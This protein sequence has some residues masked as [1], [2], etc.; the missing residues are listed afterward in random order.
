VSEGIPQESLLTMETTEKLDAQTF[1]DLTLEILNRHR[2]DPKNMISQ[3]YDGASV[4]SGEFGGVQALIQ[5]AVEKNIPYI[6][7]FN[8]RLH[9]VVIKALDGVTIISS[10]FD[11]AVMIYNF[12]KKHKVQQLC[13]GTSL[14]RLIDTRWASVQNV[15]A[16]SNS[17]SSSYEICSI[18][19]SPATTPKS[20]AKKIRT[21]NFSPLRVFIF[22]LQ[23]VRAGFGAI[24]SRINFF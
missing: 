22:F 21:K 24:K 14:S 3:C 19:F 7:C 15:F 9:L 1:T 16:R 4:M 20:G 8:H 6:H 5:K 17:G 2:I 23:F 11:Q 12:F 18:F 13:E 10:C